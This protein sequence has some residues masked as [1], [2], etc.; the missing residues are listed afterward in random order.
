MERCEVVDSVGREGEL[1]TA[2]AAMEAAMEEDTG[3][4]DSAVDT[5]ED[6]EAGMAV[7]ACPS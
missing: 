5:V 6:S 7:E 1:P 4:E 3:V 2:E